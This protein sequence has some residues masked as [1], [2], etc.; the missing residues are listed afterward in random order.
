MWVG[1]FICRGFIVGE[2]PFAARGRVAR[3]LLSRPMWVIAFTYTYA[4]VPIA[5]RGIKLF[6]GAVEGVLDLTLGNAQMVVLIVGWAMAIVALRGKKHSR[7]GRD[8]GEGDGAQ[9]RA[10]RRP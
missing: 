4:M 10:G 3:L 5:T 7:G 9:E 2:K 6:P 8:A 1:L